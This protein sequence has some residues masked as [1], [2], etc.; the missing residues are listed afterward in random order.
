MTIASFKGFV[1]IAVE[2][3]ALLLAVLPAVAQ[4]PKAVVPEGQT[5]QAERAPG[6]E[7]ALVLPALDLVDVGGY[8]GRSPTTR[9]PSTSCQS[10]KAFPAF[11]RS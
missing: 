5:E 1:R 11:S 7:A 10:S 8:N 2:G 6:G 9:N 4:S 3:A